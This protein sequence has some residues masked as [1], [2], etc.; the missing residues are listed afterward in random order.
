MKKLIDVACAGCG[1]V[2]VDVWVEGAVALNC[3][4]CGGQVERAWA[5][6]RAPGITPQGTRPERVVSAAPAMP[7]VDSKA[8]ARETQREIEAKWAHYGD[9]KIAEQSV[10]REINHKAGMADP[11][12]NP[13]PVPTPAPITMAT[14][15]AAN[16]A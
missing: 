16:A 6:V 4:L 10:G 14:M 5:F 2:T 7:R 15:T 1:H 8:I 12:G 11:M 9:E 3:H 13:L